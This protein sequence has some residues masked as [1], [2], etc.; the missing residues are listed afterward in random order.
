MNKLLILLMVLLNAFSL[1]RAQNPNESNPPGAR[2]AMVKFAELNNKQLLQT[3]AARQLFGGD[4]SGWKMDW[5][6]E[7]SASPDKIAAVAKDFSVARVQI[8][9][10]NSRVV[11]LYFYLKFAGGW[12][13]N[14]M[15][16]MA[17]TGWLE[18]A[19]E[20]FKK[21]AAP[22]AEIKEVLANAELTLSSDKMLTG[23]FQTNRLALNNLAAL[24][25]TETKPKPKKVIPPPKIKNRRANKNQGVSYALGT[26]PLKKDELEND[27]IPTTIARITAN[28]KIFPK[29]VAALKNLHFT[30]LETKSDGSIEFI[31]GGVLDNS[32]GFIYSPKNAPP[33][34]DG[35]R[36]IWVEKIAAGW[37]LFR[38][39]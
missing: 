28:A 8:V 16:A 20:T 33:E 37:Y 39:T 24:A 27:E 6:G 36:Y 29:S 1:T 3:D 19:V 13:I 15:R 25:L 11:D 18:S 35:W 12:K 23:W 14:S 10:K 30:A 5:F 4:A 22:T 26:D 21:E 32:V 9:R 2:E 7:I 31:I 38:T 17:Q 34:I